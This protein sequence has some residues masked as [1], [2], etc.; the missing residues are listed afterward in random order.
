MSEEENSAAEVASQQELDDMIAE[1][2]T[3][4]PPAQ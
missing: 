1:A 3:G 4:G 2:D